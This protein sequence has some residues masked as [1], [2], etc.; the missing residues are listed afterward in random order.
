MYVSRNYIYQ[1]I[2][3]AEPLFERGSYTK[4]RSTSLAR[5]EKPPAAFD[6]HTKYV[7]YILNYEILKRARI[8]LFS[9]SYFANKLEIYNTIILIFETY[10]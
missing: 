4:P 2:R 6:A 5:N 8:V 1:R 9:S 7:I 10:Q 3:E